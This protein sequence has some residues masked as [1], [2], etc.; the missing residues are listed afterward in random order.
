M[1]SRNVA[2]VSKS[3]ALAASFISLSSFINKSAFLVLINLYMIYQLN[4]CFI[5]ISCFGNEIKSRISLIIVL[6]QYHVLHYMLL[7]LPTSCRFIHSSL[8]RIGDFI[9]IHNDFSFSVPQPVPSFALTSVHYV[10]SLLYPHLE[11]QLRKL[12]AHRFLHV[13]S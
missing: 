10:R 8:H 3:N 1:V 7:G 4:H 12:L 13:I 5:F 9:C 6:V 2:A 11:S